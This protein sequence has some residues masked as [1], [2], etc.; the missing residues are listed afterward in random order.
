MTIAYE[1]PIALSSPSCPIPRVAEDRQLASQEAVRACRQAWDDLIDGFWLEWALN[2]HPKGNDDVA[3]PSGDAIA[4]GCRVAQ[5]MRDQGLPAPLR[6]VPD[7]EGGVCLERGD[8]ECFESVS[9]S[10]EGT[11]ELRVF[12]DCTLVQRRSLGRL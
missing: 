4:A 2:S 3:P 6:I 9:I 7:G 5:K 12:V 10:P 11:G 1:N 8:A